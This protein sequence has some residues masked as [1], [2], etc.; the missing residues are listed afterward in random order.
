MMD[1]L[2][3]EIAAEYREQYAP[4]IERVWRD[5]VESLRS[6]LHGWLTQASE[7]QDGYVADLVE[8]A[9]GLPLDEG[10]DPNSTQHEAILT[11]GF[12]LRGIVDLS[13]KSESGEIR[14]TDH[15]T[16][17]NRTEPGMVVGQ[18]E[19]LQPVLYSLAVE[20]LRKTPVKEARLSYCTAAGGYSERTVVMN[21]Q[22][23]DSGTRVLCTIDTSIRDGFFPPAP[24]EGGC[25]WCEFAPVCGPYEELRT[26]R[27]AQEP[28]E[29]LLKLRQM[30]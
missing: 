22:N 17:K 8:F 21:M 26:E 25:K 27:K 13:E 18:S 15:K 20:T 4:A 24:K 10:R 19:V 9:F 6:D 2:L 14:L 23:R 7:R 12:L 1:E 30:P 5:E 16:G 29:Q 3:Q 11:D 28:L